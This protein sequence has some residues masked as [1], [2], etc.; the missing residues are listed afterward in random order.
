MTFCEIKFGHKNTPIP[1][2][3]KPRHN[4]AIFSNIFILLDALNVRV[5]FRLKTIVTLATG[6]Q[7][8]G[9]LNRKLSEVLLLVL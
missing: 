7:N 8:L 1:L 9:R 4:Y 2:T 3:L 6:C 5:S